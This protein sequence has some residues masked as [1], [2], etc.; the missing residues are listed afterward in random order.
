VLAPWRT[1]GI[2]REFPF[3]SDFT[4]EEEVLARALGYLQASNHTLK[5]RI[6]LLLAAL[7]PRGSSAADMAPALRR[8]G[9][10][11]PRSLPQRLERRLLRLALRSTAAPAPPAQT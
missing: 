4:A 5:D 3:G 8:M 6:R 9:L 7:G 1:R 11:A 2:I 10:D